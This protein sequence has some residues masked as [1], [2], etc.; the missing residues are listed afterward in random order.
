MIEPA[1][2]SI[3]QVAERTGVSTASLRMWEARYDFPRP[4]RR[5]SGHRRYSEDECERVW[6][7]V[8]DRDA[9]LSLPA[10]I[11]KH[12]GGDPGRDSSIFAGLRRRRPDLTPYLLPKRSLLAM[13]HAIEDECCARAER[14]LLLASFQ[15]ERHYRE[16]EPRWR[17]LAR[18]ADMTVAFADFP[19]RRDP[20][21][22]PVELPIRSGEPLGR[23]WTLIC[24]ALR[25]SACL[26]A[27]E[28]PGQDHVRDSDRMFETVWTVDAEA[29]Q[30][31]LRIAAQLMGGDAPDLVE[32]MG[33]RL[34]RSPSPGGEQS[35]LVAALSSRMVAYVARSAKEDAFVEP[36]RRRP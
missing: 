28:R 15:R 3:R 26:S 1:G 23:E 2:L 32:R 7:V 18:T 33:G 13:T 10:A 31:G 12:R 14:S 22:G 29:V 34:D 25:Y 9:G 6:R 19:R 8:R 17:D 21:G 5:S 27:W 24:A 30:V 4:E 35:A 20:P 36:A 11:E 16:A